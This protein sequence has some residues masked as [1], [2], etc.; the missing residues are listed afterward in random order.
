MGRARLPVRKTLAQSNGHVQLVVH[1]SATLGHA[2]APFDPGRGMAVPFNG[3]VVSAV[4]TRARRLIAGRAPAAGDQTRPTTQTPREN[5][6]QHSN[7]ASSEQAY[8]SAE[9]SPAP[10]EARLPAAHAYP[11]RPRDPGLAPP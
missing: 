6:P 4:V 2:L 3:R 8:F 7:G 5:R 10:Q 11:R 9:Q 1:L